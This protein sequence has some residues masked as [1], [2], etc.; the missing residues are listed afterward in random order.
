[1]QL[2]MRHRP[3]RDHPRQGIEYD[4]GRTVQGK[5]VLLVQKI[6]HEP[7][8][9]A[10]YEK[11]ASHQLSHQ[12]SDSP[13]FAKRDE[14]ASVLIVKFGQ[15]LSAETS[16]HLLSQMCCLLMRRLRAWRHRPIASMPLAFRAV[17]D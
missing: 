7:R 17:A 13:I 16:P 6:I 3:P 14:R 9:E 5:L 1:M 12:A 8:N 4:F 15:S 10:F 11:A 2:H